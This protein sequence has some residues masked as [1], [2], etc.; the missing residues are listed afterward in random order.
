MARELIV[1]VKK[2]LGLHVSDQGLV[3]DSGA[4]LQPLFDVL[5]AKNASMAPLFELEVPTDGGAEVAAAPGGEGEDLDLGSIF[6]VSAS[7]ED[8][9]GL[10]DQLRS[11]SLIETAYVKPETQLPSDA[12]IDPVTTAPSGPTLPATTPDFY[13]RQLYL[14][15]APGGVDADY[16]WTQKGGDGD[17]VNI[18]DIEGGW[19]LTHEDLQNRKGGLVFGTQIASQVFKDHGTAVLGVLA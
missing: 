4:D 2:E 13:P 19:N 3:A 8:L 6:T 18:I 7:D 5:S 1:V 16:A 17:G 9:D 11:S 10:A 14:K 12:G 15:P